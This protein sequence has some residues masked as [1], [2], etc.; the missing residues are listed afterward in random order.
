M[1]MIVEWRINLI[2]LKKWIA[3]SVCLKETQY[4]LKY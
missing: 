1:K 3:A 4:T 2:P